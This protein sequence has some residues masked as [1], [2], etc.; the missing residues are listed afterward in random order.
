MIICTYIIRHQELSLREVEM[1]TQR[2]HYY[3]I[4]TDDTHT[5]GKAY[6]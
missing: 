1:I 5:L 2:V 6:V 3:V 4:A